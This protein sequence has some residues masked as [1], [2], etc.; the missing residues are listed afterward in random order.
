MLFD[1]EGLLKIAHVNTILQVYIAPPQPPPPTL[2]L[3]YALNFCFGQQ[4]P[5]IC[6]S[7]HQSVNTTS[8]GTHLF[9][10]VPQQLARCVDHQT[11]STWSSK[12]MTVHLPYSLNDIFSQVRKLLP[13]CCLLL[14]AKSLSSWVQVFAA[15]L[16]VAHQAPLSM[17][18]SKQEQWSGLPS[19]GDL[20]KPGI[21]PTFLMSPALAGGFF[22]TSATWEALFVCYFS[23]NLGNHSEEQETPLN[24]QMGASRHVEIRIVQQATPQGPQQL[25]IL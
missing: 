18:F 16:T 10:T 14:P 25:T 21:Q 15:P 7:P 23:N 13:S 4:L 12:S 6:L 1:H 5:D 24:P 9:T 8:A 22:T 11:F 20:P 2:S 19:P 3:F 17:G